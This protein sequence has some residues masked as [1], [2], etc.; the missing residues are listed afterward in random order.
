MLIWQ[1]KRRLKKNDPEI[2]EDPE[3]EALQKDLQK[4]L[5]EYKEI[6]NQTGGNYTAETWNRF[7][8]AYLAVQNALENNEQ[9]KDKL[10]EL[11]KELND[12]KGCPDTADSR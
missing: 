10:N 8:T 7:H 9:E 11:L 1:L 4:K 2:P 12:A 5:D 6:F 3:V